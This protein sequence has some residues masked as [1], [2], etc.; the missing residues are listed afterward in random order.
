MVVTYRQVRHPFRDLVPSALLRFVGSDVV[1][2]RDMA[3][4]YNIA[5]SQV[6]K[7]KKGYEENLR[8]VQC[9]R[10]SWGCSGGTLG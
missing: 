4:R 6:R 9:V 2:F 1:G 10:G 7:W 3:A 5:V 8:H